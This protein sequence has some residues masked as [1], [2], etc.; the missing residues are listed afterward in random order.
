MKKENKRLGKSKKKKKQQLWVVSYDKF[1]NCTASG[2]TCD[3]NKMKETKCIWE[4]K[5]VSLT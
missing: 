2:T 1:I 3:I 5:S 4:A